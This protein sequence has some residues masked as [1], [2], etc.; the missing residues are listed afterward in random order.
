M[1]VLADAPLHVFADFQELAF[2]SLAPG[3]LPFQFDVGRSELGG[4]F[5]DT[6]FQGLAGFAE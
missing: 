1:E 4:A 2:Q 5:A 3:D 6:L